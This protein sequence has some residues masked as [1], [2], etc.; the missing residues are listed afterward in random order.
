MRGWFVLL[1]V[2][3]LGALPGLTSE[4]VRKRQP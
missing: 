1:C 4:Y 2:L 3:A